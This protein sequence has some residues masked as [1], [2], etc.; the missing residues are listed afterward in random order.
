MEQSAELTCILSCDIESI[1]EHNACDLLTLTTT[2]QTR[3]C[4]VYNK[5]ILLD[6]LTQR[7]NKLTIRGVY[8][9]HTAKG[10]IVG[11]TCI[12]EAKPT[13]EARKLTVELLA[14]NISKRRRCRSTLR[15]D[16]AHLVTLLKAHSAESCN[17]VGKLRGE[18]V[19]RK[20]KTS[21][22]ARLID[23][24][25]EV[26]EVDIVDVVLAEVYS[27][28]I[29]NRATLDK[30]HSIGRRLIEGLKHAIECAKYRLE[31]IDRQRDK[32]LTTTLLGY[33][34]ISVTKHI[35]TSRVSI[36]GYLTEVYGVSLSAQRTTLR[37]VKQKAKITNIS[38]S[39][40]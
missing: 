21:P 28:I 22:H 30:T 3:L 32:T 4:L 27:G 6:N 8:I 9:V 37:P 1:R 14:D 39:K 33:R 24:G 25:E 26:F 31:A 38:H 16:I 34:K 40:G 12:S 2:L 17:Y 18:I 36:V 19:W 35:L 5:V 29:H 20:R 11:I 7:G 15:Q 10:D 23:R 13:S